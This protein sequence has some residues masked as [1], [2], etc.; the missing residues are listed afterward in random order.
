[1]AGK[2]DLPLP[3]RC[4]HCG[5][6]TSIPSDSNGEPSKQEDNLEWL[7]PRPV[8]ELTTAQPD[9]IL[10]GM[11]YAACKLVLM[12]SSKNYKTWTLMDVAFCVANG[13]LWWG[14]HTK[15]CPVLYLDFELLDF[16]FRWRMEQIAKAH[17]TEGRK[18]SIDAV[19][20]IG[21]KG[22]T[23]QP[24]H[25]SVIHEHIKT[26]QAG[27]VVCDPTY[28]LLGDRDENS[29]RDVAELTSIFDRIAEQTLAAVIYAQH[30]SKGNQAAKESIDR[31]AGSGVWAR[32][33][34]SIITMTKHKEEE[35]LTVEPTLRSFPRIEPFV[36]RWRLPLF[37]R[38]K[39]LDPADLKQPARVGREATY[40][41]EDLADCLNG[42]D[43]STEEFEKRF[44]TETGAS[45]STFH[46]L[47]RAATEA[48]LIHKC[49]IDQ[50]WEKVSKVKTR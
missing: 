41:V 42:D 15:K 35:C 46:R 32:D 25:W 19:K 34:D 30:F 22:K 44:C 26:A 43:L 6:C 31:G 40:S 7:K 20:R 29:S 10:R 50:K 8:S 11:L 2:V 4:G 38:D 13:L 5:T 36:V 45:A 27:L 3:R 28:K 9:Q 12:G 33:A 1:M 39:K 47:R 37:E 21:L 17:L 23:L 24:A 49:L 16:D 48:G 18:G 14:I